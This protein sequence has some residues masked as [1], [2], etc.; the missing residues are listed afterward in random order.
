MKDFNKEKMKIE[1][2]IAARK[3]DFN[4]YS[5]AKKYGK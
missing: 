1:I 4:M 5:F 2:S 3:P